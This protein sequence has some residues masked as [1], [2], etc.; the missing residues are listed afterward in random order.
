MTLRKRLV[1]G[2]QQHPIES[3]VGRTRTWPVRPGLVHYG[4]KVSGLSLRIG[5]RV[6]WFSVVP[7]GSR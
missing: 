6:A 5:D 7:R 3:R 1:W 2:V 4:V